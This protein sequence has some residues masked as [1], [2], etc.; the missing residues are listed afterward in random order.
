MSQVSN[1]QLQWLNEATPAEKP[2]VAMIVGWQTVAETINATV[3]RFNARYF[4]DQTGPHEEMKLIAAKQAVVASLK[5]LL[6]SLGNW[7][8][9]L[10]RD[11]HLS[12]ESKQLWKQV[13]PTTRFIN[14]F[15]S[16]RNCAFHFGD[17]LAEAA[18][19]AEMYEAVRDADIESLNSTLRALE[20]YGFQLRGDA[21]AAL[22]KARS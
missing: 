11:G 7:R 10:A 22:Q 2:F 15:K 5:E 12:D 14:Q 21:L 20:E 1:V 18:E 16:V 4:A 17:H 3:A 8:D 13:E 9:K 19:L 6:V